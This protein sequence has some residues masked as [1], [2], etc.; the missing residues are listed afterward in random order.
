MFLDAQ[1]Q[2]DELLKVNLRTLETEFEEQADRLL[3]TETTVRELRDQ[4]L[5]VQGERDSVLELCGELRGQVQSL[6]Q[7]CE[8][9]VGLDMSLKVAIAEIDRL[10]KEK[11]TENEI[12]REKQHDEARLESPVTQSRNGS[13]AESFGD[14]AA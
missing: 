3:A 2:E 11:L 12:E 13:I 1:S 6:Q 10:R 8:S 4:L 14:R 7:Q 9:V 5:Q